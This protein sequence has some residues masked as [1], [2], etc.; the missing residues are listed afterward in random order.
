MNVTH[1]DFNSILSASTDLIFALLPIPMLINVQ[2]NWKAK[3]AI[4]GILS[5]GIL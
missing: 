2:L 1:L 3:S 5:L 4:I